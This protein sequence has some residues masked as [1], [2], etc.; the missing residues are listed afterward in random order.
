MTDDTRNRIY[1]LDL[2]KRAD[3]AFD[4]RDM[5]VVAAILPVIERDIAAF[6][7]AN[8]GG[9]DRFIFSGAYRPA[10]PEPITEMRSNVR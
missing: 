4:A 2:L 6:L 5:T 7:E 3:V 9:H 10:Q 8:G 1:A